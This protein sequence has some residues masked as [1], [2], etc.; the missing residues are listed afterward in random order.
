MALCW[1]A[2]GFSNLSGKGFL[3][4]EIKNASDVL[5]TRR[6]IRLVAA[7]LSAP[8]GQTFPPLDPSWSA[9]KAKRTKN[10]A[11]PFQVAPNLPNGLPN[12]APFL[13]RMCTF[14]PS[15]N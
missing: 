1:I 7:L 11:L 8:C 5:F 12:L 13:P 6:R 2:D 3:R 10:V 9:S 15:H 4:N 14:T